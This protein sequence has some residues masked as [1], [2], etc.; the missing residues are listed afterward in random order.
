MGKQHASTPSS[1]KAK[2]YVLEDV[3]LKLKLLSSLE[4]SGIWPEMSN[5]RGGNWTLD[6][7]S[8]VCILL[9]VAKSNGKSGARCPFLYVKLLYCI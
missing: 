1:D 4:T 2:L 6:C 5:C 8:Y 3:V 7:F 9:F